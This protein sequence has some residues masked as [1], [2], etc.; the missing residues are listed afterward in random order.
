MYK[1]KIYCVICNQLGPQRGVNC[2]H[3]G[4][5]QR[6]PKSQIYWRNK[7]KNFRLQCNAMVRQTTQSDCSQSAFGIL[8]ELERGK[9]S[10]P[11]PKPCPP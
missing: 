5:K 1:F 10:S 8:S 4:F 2:Y 9:L 7:T 3:F 6:A 11:S